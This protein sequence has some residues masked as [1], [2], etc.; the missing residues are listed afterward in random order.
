MTLV[1]FTAL[2]KRTGYPVALQAFPKDK[3]PLAPY[4]CYTQPETN[5]FHADGIVYFSTSRIVVVLYTA[6]RDLGAEESVEAVFAEANIVWT[7]DAAYNER[8]K[9]HQITYEIEV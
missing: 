7:K 3:Q 2:L 6:L 4:L 5:N 9:L 1:E 8:E